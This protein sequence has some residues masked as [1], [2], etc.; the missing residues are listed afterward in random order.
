VDHLIYGWLFFGI[1]MALLF[2]MGS[3]WWEDEAS[4]PAAAG[5]S[6]ATRAEGN[7][8][9]ARQVLAVA[10]AALGL[11]LIWQ[12]LRAHLDPSGN[13]GPDHLEQLAGHAGWV[14]VPD[15]V[16]DWRPDVSGA[17]V[18]LRQ[19]FARGA[20]RVGLYV[21]FYRG[22]T[23]DSK[24][25]TS[26]NQLVRPGNRVWR[27]AGGTKQPADVGGVVR[28]VHAAVAAS[29]RERLAVWQWY[30]VD[31]DVTSSDVTAKLYQAWSVLRGHGDPVAW[32][33]VYTPTERGE[34]EVRATLQSFATDMG[35]PIDAVL[36]QAASE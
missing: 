27:L 36:R 10:L 32:V 8:R 31:G 19:T 2:W 24:A 17:R 7:A 12:P 26:M 13:V 28:D 15:A 9:P 22:Q 11:M 20:E 29:E 5:R 25:I 18:E 14:A 35:V 30:W 3:R 33:V 23:Q 1:V 34:P 4:A 16:S 6:N 21:A